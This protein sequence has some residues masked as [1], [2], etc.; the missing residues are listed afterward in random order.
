MVILFLVDLGR[1]HR[2]F[3]IFDGEIYKCLLIVEELCRVWVVWGMIR[4][5]CVVVVGGGIVIDV[6]GFVVATYL[7]G[8]DVVYVFIMLLGMVDAVIGGKIGVNLFE[9]KNLVGVFW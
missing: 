6:V 4:V 7:R 2:V 5:D 8:I 1:E 3:T 9:G